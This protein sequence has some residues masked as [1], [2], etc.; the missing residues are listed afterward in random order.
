MTDHAAK[1]SG[2]ILQM[3]DRACFVDKKEY[4]GKAVYFLTA[5][6]PTMVSEDNAPSEEIDCSAV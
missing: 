3:P 4:D 1:G 5:F 2:E 6:P